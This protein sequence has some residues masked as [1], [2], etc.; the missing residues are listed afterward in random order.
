MSFLSRET[1]RKYDMLHCFTYLRSSS[2]GNLPKCIFR[3]RRMQLLSFFSWYNVDIYPDLS[4]H[5]HTT[6]SHCVSPCVSQ[7]DRVLS[8]L[9]RRLHAADRHGVQRLLLA[10]LWPAG[11][12]D[13]NRPLICVIKLCVSPLTLNLHSS[14]LPMTSCGSGWRWTRW[15]ISSRFLRCLCPSTWTG[16]GS[17]RNPCTD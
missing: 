4:T 9:L 8:E 3:K 11:K 5:T 16:A 2:F 7:P 6:L 13:S 15:W 17:V 1:G 12:S 10:V 14:L